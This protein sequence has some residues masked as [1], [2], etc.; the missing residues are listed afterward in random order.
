MPLG[1]NFAIAFTALLLGVGNAA[2]QGPTGTIAGR[3]VEA[4]TE[5]P[6]V[7]ASV[8]VGDLGALTDEAG[9]FTIQN[10]PV[11]SHTLRATSVGFG[12]STR[13]V[14]V[15][16][17][18]T[19]FLMLS[20]SE[21]AIEMEE[22]VVIGYSEQE[23]GDITGV[24]ETV[25][26]EEFNTGQIISAAEL[27]QGKIAGV[28][29]LDSGEPGAG[30]RMLIRGGTSITS[31]NEPLYVVDGMPLSLP[32][33]NGDAAGGISASGRN[34]LNFLN[35]D[36]IASIT[37]LKDA[38]ATAIYGSRG[39][40]G[41]VLIETRGGRGMGEQGGQLTYSGNISGAVVEREPDMLSA[42]EFM[43]AVEGWGTEA[44]EAL[45]LDADTDWRDAVQQTGVGQDHAV[46]FSGASGD[47]TYRLSV[48][49]LDQEGAVLGT[50]VER[51]TIGLN[52]GQ[53]FFENSVR[54]TTN[55]KGS[56]ANDRFTP[57]GVIGSATA[58]A[59]TQPLYDEDNTT[60]RGF[61]EWSHV[62]GVNNPLAM[63]EFEQD[64]ATT[65]RSLGD[66]EAEVDV[67]WV[68]GL[69]GTVRLG[70]D[71]T[72]AEREVF[73]PSFL[74]GEFEGATPGFVSRSNLSQTN[75]LFDAF[76]Y[77]GF[78]LE[79]FASDLD[80]TA[81]YSY[82][83]T[84]AEFPYFEAQGLAFDYLGTEG[85][86]AAEETRQTIFSEESRLAS[87]FGR[88]NLSIDDRYLV[89]LAVRR[90]GSSK[91]G[92]D[93][94]WGWFPSAGFAWRVSEESFFNVDFFSDLKLRA[95][96]GV[97]GNQA[98]ANYQAFPQFDIG[99]P[100]A[101]YQ[102]GDSFV[103]TIRPTAVDQNIKWE[104]TTSWNFGVDW[105]VMD[106]RLSGALEF[107][108]KDT[109]D[110]IFRVPVPAGTVPGNFVTTNIGSLK[111]SGIELS[112]DARVIEGTGGGFWWN[113]G[114]NAAH[115]ENEIVDINPFDNSAGEIILTG[116]I[117]GGVGNNVQILTPG[118]EA[119]SFY[120]F[121]H[122]MEDGRPIYADLD[123]NRSISPD[124][125]LLMY[126][127]QPTVPCDDNPD[128]LCPDGVINEQ[129][130]TVHDGPTPDWIFG[131]T[132]HMGYGNFDLGFTLRAH[133]GN[134]VY[135]NVASN[136]G[137]YRVLLYNG[138]GVAPN[139]LHASVLETGFTEEQYLSD[140]YLEDASFLRMD[141]LTLGYT[142]PE[143]PTGQQ[144]RVYGTVQ[145]VFTWTEYRGVDPFGGTTV[146]SMGID[147]N[148]YPRTRTF[149]AGANVR[150]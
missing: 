141:N 73:R 44:G 72:R 122:R 11:G 64:R 129:D 145:N 3:V 96:W 1:R 32:T 12:E 127:D 142:L 7:G 20:M 37:V 82:E 34:P 14:S 90:D 5:T 132:S 144:V 27:I 45:L 2:A 150:F 19:T 139:N 84:N 101:Q 66:I 43:E 56:H 74:R 24:V 25:G 13:P 131:H 30:L 123:G 92:P 99:E 63:I 83:D 125:R 102:F 81:G 58:F 59:P 60:S 115:N 53:N 75:R 100:T 98:F 86:P 21:Q 133:I 97:N 40:N 107:Y 91:F 119:Y 140:Y 79:N 121:E 88:T 26:P 42:S 93:N 76:L 146:G 94:Q 138:S 128:E 67:P 41:V 62:Q 39:A 120:L 71:V 50:E 35:P 136:N 134:H 111:N 95:S 117:S 55:L 18:E 77:Y 148:L 28:Q 85:V 10:V 29:V 33:R 114:F 8:S 109:E 103:T 110:L 135:N 65:L 147:N 89:T 137:H 57:G 69:M 46:A 51:A 49:Y 130:L 23:A 149:T 80:F 48:G 143:F 15:R 9:R 16:S 6:V 61:Y 126:V 38:S 105:G 78:R 4:T 47:V 31:S 116:G 22:L 52:Y 87:F 70:Y 17:G 112:L 54:I 68:E 36:E 118:E 124:E 104:E 108:N 106:G 113:A